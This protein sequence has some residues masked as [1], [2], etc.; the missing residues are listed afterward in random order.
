MRDMKALD[1]DAA[2]WESLA[3][4]RTRWRNNQHPKTREDTF[5]NGTI[6]EPHKMQPLW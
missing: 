2:S 5:I 1:I 4:E 3:A 6:F